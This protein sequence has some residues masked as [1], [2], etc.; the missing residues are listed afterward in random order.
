M[1]IRQY[2][3][4]G[5]ARNHCNFFY[6]NSYLDKVLDKIWEWVSEGAARESILSQP[7]KRLLAPFKP[8][9]A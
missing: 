3:D 2:E 5:T 7:F 4:Y 6:L 1:G 8:F 9:G